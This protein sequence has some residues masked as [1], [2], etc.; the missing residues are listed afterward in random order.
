MNKYAVTITYI[1]NTTLSPSTRT[2]SFWKTANSASM[3]ISISTSLFGSLM[4]CFGNDNAPLYVITSVTAD[5]ISSDD[6]DEPEPE[7][8]PDPEPDVTPENT[9]SEETTDTEEN[10]N[11]EE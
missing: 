11:T 9:N 8:D 4:N 6:S 10:T 3:A 5:L 2:F 1:N 7:P